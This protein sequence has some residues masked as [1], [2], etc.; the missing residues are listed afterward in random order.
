VEDEK[1]RKEG[2]NERRERE[3]LNKCAHVNIVNKSIIFH[4]GRGHILAGSQA[5]NGTR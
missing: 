5:L 4:A 2:L 1:G 3:V